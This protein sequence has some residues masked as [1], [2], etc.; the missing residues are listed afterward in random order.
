[1]EQITPENKPF[2]ESPSLSKIIKGILI[3]KAY[4]QASKEMGLFYLSV[5]EI[6]NTY[7]LLFNQIGIQLVLVHPKPESTYQV[8][9]MGMDLTDASTYVAYLRTLHPD[10]S[11]LSHRTLLISLCW[12]LIQQVQ[13][14][15]SFDVTD[16]HNEKRAL[17][18]LSALSDMMT[19]YK[20]L[21]FTTESSLLAEY[22]T[23]TRK[24]CLREYIDAR[25]HSLFNPV[26]QKGG[27]STFYEVSDDVSGYDTSG[28]NAYLWKL[29]FF[30]VLKKIK[31]N[32]NATD[33]Y[34]KVIQYG[35][36]CLDF[37]ENKMER[38][39]ERKKLRMTKNKKHDKK[40]RVKNDAD[41]VKNRKIQAVKST[42]AEIRDHL[43]AIIEEHRKEM[44]MKQ[45]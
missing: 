34:E 1:M 14:E 22:Q 37:V 42:I 27:L 4:N 15:Y 20:R 18:F 7:C 23:Y 36:D 32:P 24:H 8:E 45:Q 28:Y 41:S 21:G 40:N 43:N 5:E 17:L 12:A 38:D 29:H 6:Y 2:L 26:E 39:A 44:A 25:N 11:L 35:I 16:T 30:D 31:Q 3:I 33:L 13:E 19:E 9:R 10:N